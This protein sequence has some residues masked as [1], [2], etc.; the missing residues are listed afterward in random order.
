[1]FALF[2]TV[3]SFELVAIESYVIVA[4]LWVLIQFPFKIIVVV[5]VVVVAVVHCAHD[6]LS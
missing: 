1:L 6:P 4:M 3:A 5:V 2:I